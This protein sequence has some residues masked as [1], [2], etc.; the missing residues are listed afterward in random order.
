FDSTA[1]ID[2]YWTILKESQK[3]KGGDVVTTVRHKTK[4]VRDHGRTK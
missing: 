1:S 2:A 3:K 4:S